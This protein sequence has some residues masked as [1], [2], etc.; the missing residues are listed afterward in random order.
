M[1]VRAQQ[2]ANSFQFLQMHVSHGSFQ[3]EN[4][5]LPLMFNTSR[6]QFFPLEW[7]LSSKAKFLECLK[8]V[9]GVGWS[10]GWG[11]RGYFWTFW[12]HTIH[13]ISCNIP[14][15]SGIC[16]LSGAKLCKVVE[17]EM[18]I[19]YVGDLEHY[20]KQCGTPTSILDIV[21]EFISRCCI[22][23]GQE[24]PLGMTL[25]R[26]WLHFFFSWGSVVFLGAC[27]SAHCHLYIQIYV[28]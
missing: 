21:V 8:R 12:A 6:V 7:V 4:N 1:P 24:H 11:W 26:L 20:S 28:F 22:L 16:C 18:H 14:T 27:S 17:N 25:E 15:P 19:S 23:W 10:G 9:R 3:G 2:G 13:E 5:T